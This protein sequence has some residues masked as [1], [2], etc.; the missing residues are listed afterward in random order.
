VPPD[1]LQ[2]IIQQ[3]A[4]LASFTHTRTTPPCTQARRSWSHS[5][6]QG[7]TSMRVQT[8]FCH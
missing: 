5:C 2:H 6:V 7:S 3:C 4:Q 8:C 1:T